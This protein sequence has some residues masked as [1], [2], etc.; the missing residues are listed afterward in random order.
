[1]A[2][3]QPEKLAAA[4]WH[5][6]T[7]EKAPLVLGG[8]L[9]EENEV[10]FALEIPYALS[11]LAHGRPGAEVIGLDQFAEALI[12]P[13]STHYFFDVM[14]LIRIYLL[15]VPGLYLMLSRYSPVRC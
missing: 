5:F 10:K 12:P 3:V 2:Q 13:L 7:T 1:M 15:V 11:I 9:T 14:V 8:I 6:T 4:E